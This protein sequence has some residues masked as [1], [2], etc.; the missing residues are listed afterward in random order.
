MISALSD[1]SA[2]LVLTD[3]ERF[4]PERILEHTRWF[5]ELLPVAPPRA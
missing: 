5:L 2:R 1:E 4:P 3:P